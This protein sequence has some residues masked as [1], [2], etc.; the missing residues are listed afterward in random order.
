VGSKPAT[1]EEKAGT[2]RG[3]KDW[4]AIAARLLR[5]IA[6]GFMQGSAASGGAEIAPSPGDGRKNF[7]RD[8]TLLREQSDEA[9]IR[10]VGCKTADRAARDTAAHL[11]R[12]NNFFH[13]GYRCTREGFAVEL[14]G[15]SAVFLIIDLDGSGILA[16]AAKEEFTEAITFA[17]IAASGASKNK[18]AGAVTEQTSKFPGDPAGRERAAVNIGSDDEDSLGLPRADERLGDGEGIEQTEAGAADV[19]G[20]AIFADEQAGMKLRRERRVVVMRFAGGNDPIQLL[21]S[22]GSSAQR[23]LRGSRCEGE[24]VFAFGGVGERFDAGAAAQF[25]GGHAEGAIDFLGGQQARTGHRG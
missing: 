3:K 22:T 14:H 6:Q 11:D 21:R 19:Q 12:G 2:E 24:L 7:W 1:A 8:A 10:L 17:G 20:A 23:F 9:G 16:S 15:E 5:S 13:P 25:S 4:P 18:S